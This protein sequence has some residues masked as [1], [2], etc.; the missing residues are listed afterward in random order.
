MTIT[1]SRLRCGVCGH[2]AMVSP[3][4]LGEQPPKH[5]GVTMHVVRGLKCIVCGHET[6][7]VVK[8]GP[9]LGE[10]VAAP[11]PPPTEAAATSLQIPDLAGRMWAGY[12][13]VSKLGQGGMAVVYKAHQLRLER[14]VAIKILL[15]PG[16]L[17]PSLISRFEQEARLI[18]RLHH[19]NIVTVLDFGEEQ[20]VA[21]LVMEYVEGETLGAGMGTPMAIDRALAVGAQIGR[22]LDYAHTEGV[23]H[24]D[25]KPSN[26]LMAREG[27]ALLSD[28][29]IAKV[30]TSPMGL[31]QAGTTV[32]TPEY[33]SPE[34]CR[35]LDVDA[36]S[37]IYSLGVVLYEMITGR[38][39]FAGDTPMSVMLQHMGKEPP[40]VRTLRR[41]IAEPIE[42]LLERAMAKDPAERYSSA[43]EFV[44]A[45]ESAGAG[46]APA[47]PVRAKRKGAAQ[48]ARAIWIAGSVAAAVVLLF[49]GL[50]FLR[51]ETEP[52]LEERGGL[53]PPAAVGL[54][55]LPP[56]TRIAFL[57]QRDGN[58]EIYVMNAQGEQTR[59]TVTPGFE[60]GP[61]WSP[62]GTRLAFASDRDGN[63]E[64][65]EMDADGQN[66]N[67]LTNDAASDESPS[68]SPDGTRLSFLSDRDGNLEVYAMN[69]DGSGT[70]RL[71]NHPAFDYQAIWSPD[72]SK[73]AFVSQ[74]NGNS[75][76][77]TMDADGGNP[78]RLTNNPATDEFP[79]WSPDGRR[80]AFASDRDGAFDIYVMSADGSNVTRLTSGR[81]GQQPAWSPDGKLIAFTAVGEASE[82]HVMDSD[83]SNITRLTNDGTAG[84][85]AWAP[86]GAVG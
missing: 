50:R 84:N 36:R 55:G 17:D 79:T 58:F 75:E 53:S 10:T 32:G 25:V 52:A 82:I 54:Q 63:F 76:I 43:G 83:G 15:P 57:S 85:P 86:G 56:G 65:Y 38:P 5:C 77:Y 18:A 20:G 24:R 48:R 71:T 42:E 2:E 9:H 49:A 68:W 80:I 28:F 23:V 27:W 44:D 61:S 22:A 69:E 26:I 34:Q 30:L 31:T 62:E 29:G 72:G 67:R 13:I 12:R 40:P 70:T 19:P 1:G 81:G 7:D 45:L 14:H 16:P 60:G 46:P 64:I 33:M 4:G 47:R 66:P 74:R 35:G 39:P 59:L 21:Y 8:L 78:T 37:D 11:P 51:S 41:D 6:T 73:I 3:E